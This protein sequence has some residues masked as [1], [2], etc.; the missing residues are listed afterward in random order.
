M[1]F[2]NVCNF[3]I[4][5]IFCIF[6]IFC[7][8]VSCFPHVPRMFPVCFGARHLVEQSCLLKEMAQRHV[9]CS[10]FAIN[11]EKLI[12]NKV[13]QPLD[14][15]RKVFIHAMIPAA[16]WIRYVSGAYCLERGYEGGTK[17]NIQKYKIY[18]IYKNYKIWIMGK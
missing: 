4:F 17:T 11:L 2:C 15:A 12:K 7:I 6:C 14:N 18:K 13:P 8:F 3:C 9:F 5:S 10:L 16:G 1:Q